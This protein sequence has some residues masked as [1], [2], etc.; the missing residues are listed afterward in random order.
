MYSKHERWIL[1]PMNPDLLGLYFF[2]GGR[3]NPKGTLKN[4]HRINTAIW[5]F[6]WQRN[7]RKK[8]QLW[9]VTIAKESWWKLLLDLC[10]CMDWWYYC[11]TRVCLFVRT[12]NRFNAYSQSADKRLLF[13]RAGF[14]NLNHPDFLIA[15]TPNNNSI[16]KQLYLTITS[17]CSS[18]W[19]DGI[20]QIKNWGGLFIDC[21]Q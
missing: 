4:V 3:G 17:F 16:Q 18:I 15:S 12:A 5:S 8:Y 20:V 2:G 13:T 19:N 14:Q 1:T 7:G 10:E 9:L 21:L 6:S 11:Y